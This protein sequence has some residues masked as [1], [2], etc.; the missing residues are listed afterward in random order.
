M[1]LVRDATLLLL[2]LLMLECP[3]ESICGAQHYCGSLQQL[4]TRSHRLQR[5]HAVYL[6]WPGGRPVERL[7]GAVYN[8]RMVRRGGAYLAGL[9][10]TRRSLSRA[11][12]S[13]GRAVSVAESVSRSERLHSVSSLI[14][15]F[16]HTD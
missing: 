14:Q 16:Y 7:P 11:E 8:M 6:A 9:T 4:P 3:T 15:S 10:G 13:R 2:L 12:P 1:K 5:L